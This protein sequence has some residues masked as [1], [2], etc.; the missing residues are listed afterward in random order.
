M[1]ALFFVLGLILL[2]VGATC[3]LWIT[4]AGSILLAAVLGGMG[5]FMMMNAALG[6][7]D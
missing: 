6:N 5:G 4:G 1:N 2:I 7:F 3:G